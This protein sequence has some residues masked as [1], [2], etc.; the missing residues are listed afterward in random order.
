MKDFREKVA[1]FC[2]L[3][4]DFVMNMPRIIMLGTSE[5]MVENYKGLIEY[6]DD[7]VRLR[8]NKRQIVIT[9]S[10]LIINNLQSDTIFIGGN[11]IKVEYCSNNKEKINKTFDR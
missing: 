5:V 4:K 1:E 7:L 11:I 10:D 6:T 8:A 9:G 2:E 3:P